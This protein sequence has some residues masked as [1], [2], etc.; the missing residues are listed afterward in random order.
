MNPFTYIIVLFLRFRVARPPCPEEILRAFLG[1]YHRIS[2]KLARLREL[3]EPAD[4]WTNGN[5]CRKEVPKPYRDE[6]RIKI[7]L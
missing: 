4:G 5:L 7:G 2:L 6:M 3:T 1:Y